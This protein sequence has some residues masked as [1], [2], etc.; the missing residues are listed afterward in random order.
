MSVSTATDSCAVQKALDAV[1]VLR[2]NGYAVVVFSPDEL[3]E[4]SPGKVSNRLIELGW[5]VIETLR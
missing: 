1:E 2:C 5:D 3:N 4:A